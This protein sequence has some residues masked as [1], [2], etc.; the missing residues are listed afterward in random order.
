MMYSKLIYYLKFCIICVIVT[1]LMK[2]KL[3]TVI[4]YA[5]T[6]DLY[7][8]TCIENIMCC[9]RINY[10]PIEFCLARTGHMNRIQITLIMSN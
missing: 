3:K 5:F 8:Y 9:V 1:K 4:H 7:Q 6:D 2:L 10:D